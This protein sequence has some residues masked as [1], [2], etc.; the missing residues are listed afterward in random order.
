MNSDKYHAYKK[1]LV[2]QGMN[3]KVS[4]RQA[5]K[6]VGMLGTPFT[7]IG[8]VLI[9]LGIPAIALMGL[10]IVLIILGAVMFF[11]GRKHKKNQ[12]VFLE[13]VENDPDLPERA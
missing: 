8:I 2:R 5:A 11:V 3:D 13:M 12:K 6:S 10:G 9:V 1:V 7:I 4:M